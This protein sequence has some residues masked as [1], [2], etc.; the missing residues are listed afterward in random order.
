MKDIKEE[1]FKEDEALDD[2]LLDTVNGG[3]H[4]HIGRAV[5]GQGQ[6]NDLVQH[7]QNSATLEN[8]LYHN[9]PNGAPAGNGHW[10]QGGQG[11]STMS[12]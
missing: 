9:T 10:N 6:V 8:L 3:A 2:E 4:L 5:Q 7:G 11:G 12:T 1:V